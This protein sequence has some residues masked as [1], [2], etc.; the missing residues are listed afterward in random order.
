LEGVLGAAGAAGAVLAG[1]AAGAA[2]AVLAGAVLPL[3]ELSD[4]SVP[5]LGL[6]DE[7]K[8][9]Y[10]PPPFRMKF[11]PLMSRCAVFW[12]HFGHSSRAG[13]VIFWSSSHWFWQAVHPYS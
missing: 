1:A 6:D 13:S 9:A 5:P 8:P 12:W 11:P 2:G 7:Y 3:D 4:F 10:Q